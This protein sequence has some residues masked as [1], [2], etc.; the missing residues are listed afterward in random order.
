[1]AAS[2]AARAGALPSVATST[3]NPRW[4]MA[5]LAY[6]RVA[7]LPSVPDPDP[8]WA[9]PGSVG[10]TA[11]VGRDGPGVPSLRVRARCPKSEGSRDADRRGPEGACVRGDRPPEG[12]DR[13]D[14]RAHHEAPRVRLPRGADRGVR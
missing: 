1:M 5:L 14:Q 4:G 3:G 8:T 2:T 6:A 7:P 12:R 9:S 13:G 10:A 11:L